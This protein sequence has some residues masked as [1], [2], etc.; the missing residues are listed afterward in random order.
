MC[1]VRLKAITHQITAQHPTQLN[2]KLRH[3]TLRHCNVQYSCT[4]HYDTLS[5]QHIQTHN[6]TPQNNQTHR[7]TLQHAQQHRTLH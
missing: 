4:T 2:T 3:N 6:N 5:T 1:F 7:Y